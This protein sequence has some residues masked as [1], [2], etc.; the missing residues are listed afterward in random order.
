MKTQQSIKQ[1]MIAL[2]VILISSLSYGQ[3]YNSG[4]YQG[5][6][7]GSGGDE[8]L[9]KC[10]ELTIFDGWSGVSTYVSPYEKD[11]ENMFDPI[12]GALTILYNFNGVYWPAT[13]INTLG[14]WDAYSGYVIKVSNDANLRICGDELT[15][16]TVNLN[17]T[18]DLIPVLSTTSANVESLF[19]GHVGFELA[20]AIGGSGVYWPLYNINT[21]F[22]LEPGKAYYVY[23]TS[24]GTINFSTKSGNLNIEKHVEYVNASPWN[25]VYQ[26]P[27]THVVALTKEA[28]Q[29][30]K[31]GDIIGAF[32]TSGLCAG[33]VEYNDKE[34]A[35]SLNG[36]DALTEV[37]DGF[38]ENEN[39]NYKLYHPSSHKIFD[40]EVEYETRFDNSGQFHSNGMSAISGLTLTAPMVIGETL[41]GLDEGSDI[42]IFPNPSDGIFNIEGTSGNI[43]IT[44]FNSFGIEIS[45]SEIQSPGFID[46]ST[47][48]KGVYFIR[49][50]SEKGSYFE[51]LILN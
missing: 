2:M 24:A 50:E 51:K 13:G 32:T 25:D 16:K 4:G 45:K 29:P 20:K 49:I 40:M 21:L 15:D 36:E 41:S 42:R 23:T 33:L 31:P 7:H 5:G 30:L 3:F 27:V 1:I 47:Q 17:A 35:L 46:L 12:D 11:A 43:V 34:T 8:T 44:I 14:N 6:G 37:T 9:G 10:Q 22:V 18:W 28:L 19:S 48:A 39:V 38:A 26:T